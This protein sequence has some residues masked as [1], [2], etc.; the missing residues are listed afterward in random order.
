MSPRIP[1]AAPWGA[2]RL[3]HSEER[4]RE[5]QKRGP[6]PWVF[7]GTYPADDFTTYWSPPWQNSFTF[8]A[9]REVAFRLGLDGVLEFLG[10]FDLTAGAVTGTVAFTLPADWRVEP[11]DFPIIMDMGAGDFNI[12]RVVVDDTNGHVTLHWPVTP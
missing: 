10:Q 12:V 5:I 9:G 4:I 6:G 8:V 3:A 1:G 7:V 11:M 2:R